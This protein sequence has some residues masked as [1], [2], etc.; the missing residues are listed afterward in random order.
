MSQRILLVEDE[1]SIA[2]SVAFT[3]GS[4]GFQVEVLADGESALQVPIETYDVIILDQM[5]PKLSGLEV[6][7]RIRARSIVPILILTART[8]EL[9]RVLGLDAGADD[10]ITKPFSTAELF[11]RVRAVLRRRAMERSVIEARRVVGDLELDLSSQELRIGERLID[12]TQ[13]EFRLLALLGAAPGRVFSRRE[14]VEHLWHSSHVGDER[15][16]DVHVK[17]LR[18]KIERNPARPTRL[19]TVR[20][21]GYLLQR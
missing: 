10:Y 13:S 8:A 17:N 7:R 19:L 1:P 3:L 21:V 14:I 6:C 9:D 11:S 15:T 18:R 2:E 16:C 20:G 4:E 5:L 12:L